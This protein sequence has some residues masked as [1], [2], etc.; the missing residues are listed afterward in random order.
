[1]VEHDL[2]AHRI[3]KLIEALRSKALEKRI[4]LPLA[5]DP[6][7]D[8]ISLQIPIYHFIHGVDI[9]L[10]ITVDGD[11]HIT[12]I[13]RLHQTSENGILMPTVAALAD[14]DIMGILTGKVADDLPRLITGT[15]I[16]EKDPAVRTDLAAGSQLFDLLQ[17]HGCCHGK[18]LFFIVA[19]DND[20]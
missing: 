20:I 12:N 11:R 4:C 1:M 18:H 2:G 7:N 6:V 16:D 17:K 8:L 15:V 19:G 13:F 9:I 3:Q 5:A 10:A 14:T